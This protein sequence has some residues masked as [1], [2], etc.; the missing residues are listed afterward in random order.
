MHQDS[1]PDHVTKDAMSFMK[2]YNI[3][4]IMPHEQLSKSSNAASINYSV[5]DVKKKKRV[6]K[7]NMLTLQK[8]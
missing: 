6:R 1:I 7:H 8:D 2:E 4:V 3:N 5:W